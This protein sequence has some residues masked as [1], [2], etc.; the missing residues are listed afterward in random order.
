LT[1]KEYKIMDVPGQV[2][3][4]SLVGLEDGATRGGHLVHALASPSLEVNFT[5]E[6]TM[7][8]KSLDNY[9]GLTLIHP[10]RVPA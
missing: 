5:A 6:P 8:R 2:E 9:S 7:L 10:T 3:A 4:L 1:N